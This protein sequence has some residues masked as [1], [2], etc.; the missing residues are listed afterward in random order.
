MRRK[1]IAGNW[2][3]HKTPSETERFIRKFLDLVP[4]EPS[5]KV[6]IFPPF[7]SLERAGRFLAPTTVELGAQDVHFHDNGAFT[8]EIASSMIKEC[9]GNYVL[10]GHSERRTHFQESDTI[11]NRKLVAAI[12]GNLAPIICIG[13][14]ITEY[15]AG[16][17]KQRLEAQLSGGLSKIDPSQLASILIA[18][19]PVWAIGTGE[20]ASPATAQRTIEYIRQWIAGKYNA[21]SADMVPILYGGSV[22]AANTRDL[23]A[24]PDIDGLLVGGASLDPHSFAAIVI[25]SE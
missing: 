25:A 11:V 4:K 15:R 10:V 17:T 18:Y 9:G 21:A 24:Q 13:E 22:T 2:K 6:I 7:T 1:I 16:T 23:L 12:H 5:C 8:G 14:T 3:M 20:T 19:E